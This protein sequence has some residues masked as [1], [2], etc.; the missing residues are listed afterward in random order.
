MLGVHLTSLAALCTLA[1]S[2]SALTEA[3]P[4]RVQHRS[5]ADDWKGA[6]RITPAAG[7]ID[8]GVSAQVG[9]SASADAGTSDSGS[10]VEVSAKVELDVDLH[11]GF[12]SSHVNRVA[13]RISGK[14]WEYGATYIALLEV[15]DKDLSVF[16][17]GECS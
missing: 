16:S 12:N 5:A 10:L 9:V 13:Q 14:S 7:L 17:T 15:K 2:L 3:K 8:L 11:A 4:L 6:H 1:L